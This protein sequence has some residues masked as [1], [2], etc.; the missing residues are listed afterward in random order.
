MTDTA[1]AFS[2]QETAWHRTARFSLVPWVARLL[3]NGPLR[4]ESKLLPWDTPE[5]LTD[6]TVGALREMM[7]RAAWQFLARECGWR[8]R[9]AVDVSTRGG[10]RSFRKR[11]LWDTAADETLP[12]LRFTSE[13]IDLLVSA[14]NHTREGVRVEIIEPPSCLSANGDLL[15]HHLVFRRLTE[16]GPGLGIPRE[17]GWNRFYENP[18]NALFH[19]VSF[20]ESDRPATH[21]QRLL[22]PDLAPFFPWIGS[23]IAESWRLRISREPWKTPSEA[24]SWFGNA[25]LLNGELIVELEE[26]PDLLLFLFEVL[27]AQAET[28]EADREQFEHACESLHHH[29][30]RSALAVPWFDFLKTTDA[31]ESIHRDG[32]GLHP[33]ERSGPEKCFLATWEEMTFS[34]TADRLTNLRQRVRPTL[35]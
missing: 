21:W 33:I 19:V 35:S 22:E 2:D 12:P 18:L 7:N 1:P 14:Y 20:D 4:G 29:R 30:K 27:A 24:G 28:A 26:R 15:L 8:Q 25:A 11:R 23:R 32:I 17:F 31:L 6:E 13:A 16:A 10:E 3:G 5:G 34:A 9:H